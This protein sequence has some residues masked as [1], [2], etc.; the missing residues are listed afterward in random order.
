M[1]AFFSH[2]INKFFSP[3]FFLYPYKEKKIIKIIKI[4]INA[5]I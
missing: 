4:N 5:R 3:Y 2:K 1:N